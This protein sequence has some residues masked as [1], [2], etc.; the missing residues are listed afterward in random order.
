MPRDNR[1]FLKRLLESRLL[2]VVNLV[3]IVLLSLSLGRELVR[4]TDIQHDINQ[5]Q[6]ESNDLAARNLQISELSIAMQTESYIEREARLKL[7]MKKQGENVVIVKENLVG[8]SSEGGKEENSQLQDPLRVLEE[9]R[10]LNKHISNTAKWWYY[11]FD[12]I[13]YNQLITYE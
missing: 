2:F 3:I 10:D 8:V 5:L 1:S 12:K 9:R 13:R 4:N 11:F 7:G 6:E